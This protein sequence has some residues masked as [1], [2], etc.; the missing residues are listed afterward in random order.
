MEQLFQGKPPWKRV[1]W[2]RS[3]SW[4]VGPMPSFTYSAWISKGNEET[5]SMKEQIGVLDREHKWELAKKMVN[6]YELVYTHDDERLPPSLSL[7]QP[8]SRSYFK[9]IEILDVF[10]FFQTVGKDTYKL[11][12]AHV[13]EGPG[14]FI[15]AF[16]HRADHYKKQ[17]M[18][19]VAMTL[20]PTTSHVPGW[21]KA[22][23]FLQKY[24]HVKIHYGVDGTGDIY[25]TQN[26]ASFEEVCQPLGVHLFTADGG[27]DFSIDYSCQEQKVF[28]L[29]VC[30]S[31]IGLRVL[32]QG[33]CFV[34]KI[35]D[36]MSPSTQAL[37]LLLGRSFSEWTL[38]KPAMTRPCNSE[39]YFLGKGFRGVQA[40][41]LEQLSQMYLHAQEGRFP[42]T[43]DSSWMKEN[44]KTFFIHHNE[45]T[46]S[47]QIQSIQE[48]IRLSE[49]QDIWWS[50]WLARC[51]DK[52]YQWCEEFHTLATPRLSYIAALLRKYPFLS[53]HTFQKASFQQ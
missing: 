38:Y 4:T 32:K 44:E 13:A 1:E 30:S 27:F 33:G 43:D 29:L 23:A 5:L 47:I 53:S 3:P 10:Q 46:A 51:L 28:Q 6:P 11:R 39:R 37:I 41:V 12:S 2:V 19:S 52:S 8:L 40:A 48:A 35:F 42:N 49:D 17:V 34:L 31:Q 26:Q 7:E 50:T 24:K 15:Q 14:G 36:C 22:T 9:M 21:K 20:R 25:S 16:A 18:S 45:M